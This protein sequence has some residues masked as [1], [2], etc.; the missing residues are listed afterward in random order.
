[1]EPSK[2]LIVDD[3]RDLLEMVALRLRSAGFDV[4]ASFDPAEGLT[5]AAT[6]KPD[7][8]L[9]D[10]SMPGMDGWEFNRR[11]REIPSAKE[12]PVLIM[13]AWLTSDLRK[14]AS[15]AGA[16]RVLLKPFDE[17]EIVA[18]LSAATRSNPP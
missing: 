13:T 4:S 1:M 16:L 12:I 3:E 15:A 8:V 11:L 9:L 5:R 10:V 14:K 2:V 18:A 7:A 6:F 17:K